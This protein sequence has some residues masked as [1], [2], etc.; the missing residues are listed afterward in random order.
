MSMRIVAEGPAEPFDG[1]GF[2]QELQR[3][4][5]TELQRRHLATPARLAFALDVSEIS[6]SGLLNRQHWT[7]QS[8]LWVAE[9]LSL[10]LRLSVEM[11]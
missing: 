7:I 4:V 10:P 5:L 3:A 9:R 2:Q 11:R 8:L 1:E 6:A